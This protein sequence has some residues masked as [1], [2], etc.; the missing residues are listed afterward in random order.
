M[1]FMML[2]SASF[3]RRASDGKYYLH[4]LA[5]LGEVP[6]KIKD[7]KILGENQQIKKD[8]LQNVVNQ[9]IPRH[10]HGLVMELADS[11]FKNEYIEMTDMSKGTH[12]T[13][14]IDLLIEVF[15]SM[16]SKNGASS[17]DGQKMIKYL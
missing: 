5:F 13:S 7:L 6:P 9:T 10:L 12:G 1:V 16:G 8:R 17:V 14:A 3:K 15:N 11:I 2:W 4:H